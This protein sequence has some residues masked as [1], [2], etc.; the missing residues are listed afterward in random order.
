MSDALL[1]DLIDETEV[2]EPVSP[3]LVPLV[4]HTDGNRSATTVFVPTATLRPL[5]GP[6]GLL[7]GDGVKPGQNGGLLIGNGADGGL[8]Q[9]GGNGGLL[10]GNGGNGGRA[11]G[12]GQRAA[13]AATQAGSATAARAATV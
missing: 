5:I 4:S 1:A 3:L 10:W 11:A 7:I 6:G 12:Y 8:R 9:K 13:T 2:S